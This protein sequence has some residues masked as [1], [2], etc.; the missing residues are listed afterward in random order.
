MDRTSVPS[1]TRSAAKIRRSTAARGATSCT[2]PWSTPHGGKPR[3]VSL[4]F[5]LREP[6]GPRSRGEQSRRPRLLLVVDAP[7][8][9][10]LGKGEQALPRR[11]D[12]LLPLTAQGRTALGAG[13]A[14]EPG[15]VLA[16]RA[17]GGGG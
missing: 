10:G 6:Q 4:L 1:Q 8:G 15:R 14:T 13:L 11:L 3:T 7:P 5:Q 17:R 16:R 12:R 2:A 9:E